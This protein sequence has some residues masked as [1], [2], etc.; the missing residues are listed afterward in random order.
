MRPLEAIYKTMS[1][2]TDIHELETRIAF[3][4]DQIDHLNAETH[5]LQ[6]TTDRL[7]QELHALAHWVKPMVQHLSHL[8]EADDSAPPPHY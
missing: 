7:T 5:R 4:E 3:L 8:G 2:E 1:Q 6:Q